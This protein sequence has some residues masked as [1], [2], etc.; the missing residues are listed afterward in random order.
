MIEGIARV[1]ISKQKF[2]FQDDLLTLRDF[3]DSISKSSI[4]HF[5][6]S[7]DKITLTSGSAPGL[8]FIW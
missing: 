3:L 5:K 2:N 4:P 7:R 6:L 1:K 8:D